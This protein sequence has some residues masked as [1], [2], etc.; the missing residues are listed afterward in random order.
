MPLS[1]QRSAVASPESPPGIPVRT[2]FEEQL[3]SSPVAFVPNTYELSGDP[4]KKLGEEAEKKVFDLVGQIGRDIP[5]IQ[6]ICF[7]GVRVV[8]RVATTS[9]SRR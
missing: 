4:K 5:G 9:S 6:I 8:A 1:V 2:F 7:H 3:S